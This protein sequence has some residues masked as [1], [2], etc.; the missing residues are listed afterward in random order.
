MRTCTHRLKKHKRSLLRI[1]T[2]KLYCYNGDTKYVVITNASSGGGGLAADGGVH[3]SGKSYSP[4]ILR[5]TFSKVFLHVHCVLCRQLIF[6]ANSFPFSS[7]KTFSILHVSIK[8]GTSLHSPHTHMF[9]REG[10]FP[11]Y[12]LE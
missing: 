11:Y 7:C 5:Y 12:T 1:H 4:Y 6:G 3:K 2:S 8:K 10:V 9:P